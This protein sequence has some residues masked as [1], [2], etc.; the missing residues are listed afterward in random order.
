MFLLFSSQDEHGPL[1]LILGAEKLRHKTEPKTGSDVVCVNICPTSAC[2]GSTGHCEICASAE[3]PRSL[4]ANRDPMFHVTLRCLKNKYFSCEDLFVSFCNIFNPRQLDVSHSIP[5]KIPREAVSLVM[6]FL[7]W[8]LSLLFWLFFWAY[9]TVSKYIV[10]AEK[11]HHFL[12]GRGC[13]LGKSS[14]RWTISFFLIYPL[15]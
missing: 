9:S 12:W 13:F 10:E 1:P 2:Q 4:L 6:W 7:S 15:L 5:K 8:L 3:G 14:R 11:V